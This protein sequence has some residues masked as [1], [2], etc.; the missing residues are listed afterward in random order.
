MKY[1]LIMLVLL[2][3]GCVFE[4]R[5]IGEWTKLAAA[6]LK[7]S[8]DPTIRAEK[9]DE[10]PWVAYRRDRQLGIVLPMWMYDIDEHQYNI[11]RMSHPYDREHHLVWDKDLM[12]WRPRTLGE[13]WE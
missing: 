13:T 7:S 3:A 11:R 4:H 6:D 5:P 8:F 9:S 12:I 10:S 1:A 2:N